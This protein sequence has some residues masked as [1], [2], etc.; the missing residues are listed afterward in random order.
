M[1]A[2]NTSDFRFET[3]D[4]TPEGQPEPAPAPSP[5]PEIPQDET[6]VPQPHEEEPAPLF[7]SPDSDGSDQS[8]LSDRSDTA[9]EPAPAPA[10]ADLSEIVRM[11]E[12]LNAKFD[13]RIAYDKHKDELFDKMYAELATYKNDLYAKIMK[14]FV[15]AAIS[16]LDDTNTFITRLENNPTESDPDKMR[17]FINNLPLDL[18][19]I[20]ENNG[21]ELYTDPT[22]VFDPRTQ[23]AVRTEPTA[24]EADDK[25]IIARVRQGYRWNGSIV[26]P[27]MVVISKY[28][29]A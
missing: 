5:E 4:F 17:K 28:K 2:D 6:E 1:I 27:E 3:P 29:P 19:D 16:L 13:D 12:A 10:S 21:V 18:E 24:V 22:E 26:R 15:T 20:L 14:P 7:S 8:D 11:L 25:R 23:R 9:D